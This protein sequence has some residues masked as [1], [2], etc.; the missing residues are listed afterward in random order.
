VNFSQKKKKK[1]SFELKKNADDIVSIY[2][3]TIDL[4]VSN[5]TR[6]FIAIKLSSLCDIDI[7]KAY[8]SIQLVFQEVEN[9]LK[10]N[11]N[12]SLSELNDHLISIKSQINGVTFNGL[13]EFGMNYLKQKH[14]RELGLNLMSILIEN[15]KADLMQLQSLF[16]VD[17]K[18]LRYGLLFHSRVDRIMTYGINR[19][20]SIMIDAEQSYIQTI[21]DYAAKF[22]ALKYNKSFCLVLQ[23]IQCYLKESINKA[24]DFFEFVQRNNLKLG[25]K[26]VRGAYM[27]EETRLANSLQ[28][29][30]P[31][32]SSIDDTHNS[33]NSLIPSL[34]NKAKEDDKVIY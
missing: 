22:Y 20:C 21:I 25:I 7:L 5:S 27:T 6:N 3:K 17:E 34:M 10:N 14:T 19:K 12:I 16:E 33:Y 23:T 29:E 32:F 28:Y 2:L 11:A 1:Y 31:I 13:S 15:N 30:N 24:Q 9:K 18:V 8:N 4:A 26:I